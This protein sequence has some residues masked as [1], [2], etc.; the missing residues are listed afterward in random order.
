MKI[1]INKTKII[2]T[3]GPSCADKNIMLEMVKAG[4]D[5]FR[6][7]FSHGSYEQHLEGFKR[8]NN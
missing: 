3:Y 4:V 1:N 6:F 2:A 8:V 7:N 5:V